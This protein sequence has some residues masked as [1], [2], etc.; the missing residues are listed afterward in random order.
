MHG[1]RIATAALRPNRH[2]R[3]SCWRM[4]AA[5]SC[6]HPPA[7]A[8]LPCCVCHDTCWNPLAVTRLWSATRPRVTRARRAQAVDVRG[9]PLSIV[10]DSLKMAMC[11][12]FAVSDRT[13]V[14]PISC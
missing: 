7:T 1:E 13:H 8:A 14:H 6:A 5:A 2:R 3:G 9:G 11:V 10:V 4:A 12:V